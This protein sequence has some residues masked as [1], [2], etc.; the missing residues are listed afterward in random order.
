MGGTWCPG[1][2][3]KQ[4]SSVQ[5]VFLTEVYAQSAHPGNLDHPQRITIKHIRESGKLLCPICKKEYT[6]SKNLKLHIMKT[7]EADELANHNIEP[8]QVIGGPLKRQ[9]LDSKK[10]SLEDMLD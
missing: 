8:D 2:V 5:E 7:H 4:M 10:T 9:K 1:S 3:A 6:H